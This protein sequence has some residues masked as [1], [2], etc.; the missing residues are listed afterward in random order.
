MIY[1]LVANFY[2][3]YVASAAGTLQQSEGGAS[4]HKQVV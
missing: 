2:F 1:Q 4:M 3:Q